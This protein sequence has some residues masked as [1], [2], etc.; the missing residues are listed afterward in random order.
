MTWPE[1]MLWGALKTR[2]L[3][4]YKFRKQSVI[5]SWIVDFYCPSA[6]LVV[7]V[8]GESHVDPDQ[9]AARTKGL[10]KFG[11]RVVRYTNDEVVQDLDAVL[12]EILTH[13]GASGSTLP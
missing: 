7:E 8:D 5:G 12:E 9:D 4:N 11:V 3:A 13:L 6:R 2:Q 10:E 1:K